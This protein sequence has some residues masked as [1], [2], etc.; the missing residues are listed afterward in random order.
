[1][2]KL[3]LPI[4]NLIQQ[5]AKLPGIGPKSSER[6]VYHLLKKPKDELSKFSYALDHLRDEI[7]TCPICQNFIQDN[8]CTI[9]NDQQR[10]PL[11]ICIVAKPQD[12]S[13]I[14]KTNQFNGIYHI[15][16]GVLSPLNGITDQDLNI[17][18]LINRIIQHNIKE[19]ILALNPDIEGEQTSNF[20]ARLIK[21]NNTSVKITRLAR[22]LPIGSDIEY[23]DEIT[24][25]DAIK[26][27]KEL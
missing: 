11:V 6:L 24:V 23:A 13:V 20:I 27:R 1:M 25:S 8:H 18:P 3:P 2:H 16:G 12:L 5:F 26:G 22:G 10:D 17:K 19:T 4:Q 15:L 9:C 21:E 14:E 7:S